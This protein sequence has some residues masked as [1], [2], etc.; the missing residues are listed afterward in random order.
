MAGSGDQQHFFTSSTRL[1]FYL[2]MKETSASTTS[3]IGSH[4][5]VSS[6]TNRTLWQVTLSKRAILGG[7]CLAIV[8]AF[9]LATV[10]QSGLSEQPLMHVQSW[11]ATQT[12]SRFW[13][14]C[15]LAIS[16]LAIFLFRFQHYV[17]RR[18]F[19]DELSDIL[20]T[21]NSLALLDLSLI[22]I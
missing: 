14:W 10:I 6:I 22:H 9:L 3:L 16:S 4:Q 17:N 18:P 19:W 7:D 21:M 20:W 2:N 12:A 11:F 1:H 5:R 8:F 15:G 13:V